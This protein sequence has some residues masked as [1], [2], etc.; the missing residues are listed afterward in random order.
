MED[1]AAFGGYGGYR[2]SI[3]A[4]SAVGDVGTVLATVPARR[5]S[6]AYFSAEGLEGL[7]KERTSNI[8]RPT[9]NIE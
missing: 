4:P 5:V 2:T 9:S 6:L 3:E 7:L 8:E 1:R